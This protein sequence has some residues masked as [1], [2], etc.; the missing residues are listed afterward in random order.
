[1]ILTAEYGER[2]TNKK[3]SKRRVYVWRLYVD[4]VDTG[5]KFFDRYSA[6]MYAKLIP[7]NVVIS[8]GWINR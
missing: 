6:E 8:R 1:M 2:M 7:G 4:G 3:T 5:H